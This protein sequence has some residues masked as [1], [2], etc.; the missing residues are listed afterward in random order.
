MLTGENEG[1]YKDYGK[2]E[3]LATAFKQAFVYDGQ[4]SHFRQRTVGNSPAGLDFSKFVVSIQNHDQIGNRLLG[5]RLSKLVS[6]EGLKLGAGV[7]L[8]SPFVPM[9][10]M[11]EEFAE[12]NP[13]QYFISH[14]DPDLVKAV[15]QGRKREF[16]Y[17]NSQ[18]KDDFSDPQARETFN[19]S[20][21]DWK[22]KAVPAKNTMFKYYKYLIRLKKDGAF[23]AFRNKE[24]KTEVYEEKKIL[25]VSSETDDKLMAIFNFSNENEEVL[26]PEVTKNWELV[27]ASAD[28][29]W[30]GT[31]DFPSDFSGGEKVS[32]PAHSLILCKSSI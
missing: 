12:E 1:Y 26:L 5:D 2:M 20:K 27:L 16:E 3:Q 18:N 10:F 24:I 7:I 8:I 4:Y 19:D 28:K 15:Q 22:F 13:F 14:G 32:L 30:D 11:G 31:Y 29:K 23:D 9:L 6:F 17:F 25:Q 21:L